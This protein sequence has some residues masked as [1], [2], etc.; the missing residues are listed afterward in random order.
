MDKV[1]TRCRALSYGEFASELERFDQRAQMPRKP[2]T[3]FSP[4]P[5]RCHHNVL[6]HP[7]PLLI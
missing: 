7:T 6:L 2:V 5:T 3:Y 1:A 4:L